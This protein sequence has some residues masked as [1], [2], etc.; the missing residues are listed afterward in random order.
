MKHIFRSTFLIIACLTLTSCGGGG[1]GGGSSGGGNGVAQFFLT[2]SSFSFSVD[3]DTSY[4]GT[5]DGEGYGDKIFLFF[6]TINN[7]RLQK[8]LLCKTWI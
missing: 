8:K 7:L 6:S 3:E 2:I 5:L 4:S 1:G